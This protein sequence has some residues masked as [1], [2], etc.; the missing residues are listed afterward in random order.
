MMTLAEYINLI[1]SEHAGKVR[2]EATVSAGVDPLAVVQQALAGFP[3]DF[4]IDTATGVQLDVVGIWIGRSRRIET[5]L[6]GV[7]F[8]WDGTAS[9]GWESGVWQGLY[10]PTSG[11]VDLPDDAY[12]TLLKAKIAANNWNGSI[13]QAYEIWAAAFDAASILVIQD[14]QDMSM[15]IGIAGTPLSIVEQQLLINGYIP[16]KPEGV[17]VSYYAIAPAEGELFAWDIDSNGTFGGW[18][19][20][21]WAIELI[22]S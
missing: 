11:L 1:T 20:G 8:E 3:A 15:V 4:D 22:P 21:Q 10:D 7:Y 2:F 18:E 6:T 12:R 14:N 13:P 9:V 17:R 5:P 16:L 19:S